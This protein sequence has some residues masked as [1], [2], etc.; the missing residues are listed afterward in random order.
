MH[1]IVIVTNNSD[2]LEQSLKER[3]FN[4]IGIDN[5]FNFDEKIYL[6]KEKEFSFWSF[7]E[8]CSFQLLVKNS[9]LAN[10]ENR[11]NFENLI[12]EYQHS[13]DRYKFDNKQNNK[14][15]YKIIPI[16]PL[17]DWD[18]SDNCYEYKVWREEKKQ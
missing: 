5:I 13:Y 18:S 3:I 10:E 4:F 9:F 1:K 11:K 8:K 15:D 17:E 7:K 6:S 16:N 2:K 14:F 12:S